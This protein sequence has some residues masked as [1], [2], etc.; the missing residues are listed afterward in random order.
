ML[1]M[2]SA[3]GHAYKVFGDGKIDLVIEMGLGATGGEW[4]HVAERLSANHTVL[5]YER[6]RDIATPRTPENIAREL[7]ALLNELGCE[8]KLTLVAH[9][10]GGLYAQ[11]FARLYPSS[12]KGVVL[13]DPLSARDGEYRTLLT[14]KEQKKSGFNKSSN[15]VI[16]EKLAKL[17]MGW[18]IKSVMR[19]APP[20]Y[21]YNGFS[22]DAREYILTEITKPQ[23][24]ASALEEYRLAHDERYTAKLV[25]KG[26]FP[27]VPLALI[28][29]TPAFS[30]RET[31]EFGHTDEVFAKKV[32]DIWQSFMLDHLAF[33]RVSRHIQAQNSGHFIHLTEPERIDE[34][35]AW[36]DS[37]ACNSAE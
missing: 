28:T 35:L 15:L 34:A 22:D 29:H 33:S 36:M 27:D 20:F 23:I 37:V 3:A 8:E 30:I 32:E 31:M 16:M 10:Q 18:L 19:S 21:Y 24:Y 26:D 9:S 14:P 25:D 7:Y 11:Q 4:W 13:L 17:H 5:L 6:S 12:V 1:Q 2:L